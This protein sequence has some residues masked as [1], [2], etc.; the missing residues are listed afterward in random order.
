MAA[1]D[2]AASDVAAALVGLQYFPGQA[3][4]FFH[5]VRDHA[6]ERCRRSL[7]RSRYSLHEK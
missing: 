2:T 3:T 1:S 4:A 5:R 7:F 6:S